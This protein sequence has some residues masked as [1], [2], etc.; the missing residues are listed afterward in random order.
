MEDS[1]LYL[2]AIALAI[3]WGS[4]INIYAVLSTLGV[5]FHVNLLQL[6]SMLE[7]VANPFILSFALL[8]F[9]VGFVVEKI[10][11]IDTTWDLFHGFFKIALG[12]FLASKVFDNAILSILFAFVGFLVSS[13]AFLFKV[14]IRFLINLT[15][16]PFSNIFISLLE[17]F[18][19]IVGI[20]L[21]YNYPLIFLSFFACYIIAFIWLF[22]KIIIGVKKIF[23]F[24]FRKKDKNI[25][26]K[27]I[28]Y[29]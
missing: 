8:M 24:I 9:F 6:P 19:V 7:F 11:F 21:A 1:F 14:S 13:V 12:I 5:S 29:K 28:S 26:Q 2:L 16:Q 23:N 18:F 17:D 27:Q 22:P 20:V 25:N 15:L 10:P 3:S 4:G